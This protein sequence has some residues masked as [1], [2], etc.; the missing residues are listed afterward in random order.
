[1]GR[2]PKLKDVKE[3]PLTGYVQPNEEKA[4][5]ALLLA[6]ATLWEELQKTEPLLGDAQA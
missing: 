5:G 3:T 2:R 1:M 4:G 6:V